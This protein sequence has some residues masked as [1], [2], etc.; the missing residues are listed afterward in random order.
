LLFRFRRQRHP[1]SAG[2]EPRPSAPSGTERFLAASREKWREVP[3]G[4]DLV[5]RIYSTDL[6]NL[7]DDQ[8]VERWTRMNKAGE[9]PTHR[10]W[11]QT[12]YREALSGKRVVEVGSGLGFDGIF[13]MRGGARWIFA[14]IVEDN[15]KIVR[16]LVDLFGLSSRAE[17]LWIENPESLE[18]I[19]GEVDAVWAHGSLH[20]AP[21]EIA[22]QESQILLRKL[23]PGGRWIELF[24]PYER[25]VRQ[26]RMPFSEWGRFTDGERTPWAEWHDAERI[27]QRL[28][29]AA[30]TVILDY[31]FGGGQ[32]GWLDLRV[33][34]PN[35][36]EVAAAELEA[37]LRTSDILAGELKT[38]NGRIRRRGRTVVFSCT[39]KMW[40]YAAAIDLRTA[41]LARHLGT[42]GDFMW[43]VDLEVS[44]QSG[45]SGFV[46]TGNDFDN[47]VGREVV[48]DA[49]PATQR[50]TL[51]TDGPDPPCFLLIRNAAFEATSTG[52]LES[53]TIRC[54]R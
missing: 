17:Y 37:R 15:L 10:G 42:H 47:F 26:G 43:S 1:E 21:F 36:G 3:A 50:L 45:A 33:D 12:M 46:L 13:F 40:S 30:T 8:L 51:T 53:G 5:D 54:S 52:T 38:L 34:R 35:L 18:A 49:R 6:L 48:L 32:Y 14:D 41:E 31:R 2:Q 29:P 16:R 4:G 20:H 23:K 28:F 25:W 39:D 7:P 9:E 27:K 24:Y 22:R 44:L 19:A 11:Y